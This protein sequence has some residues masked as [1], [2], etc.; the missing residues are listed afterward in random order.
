MTVAINIVPGFN[1]FAKELHSAARDAYVAWRDA[2]R[3]RSGSLCSD[4]RRSR[5]R[6]RYTLRHCRQN[7]QSIR[8]DMHAKAYLEKDMVSFSKE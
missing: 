6:F 4:M 7:E 5:L 8:A 1:E 2:G 3:P